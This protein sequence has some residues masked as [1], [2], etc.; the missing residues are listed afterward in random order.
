MDVLRT[1][2]LYLSE[3]EV[4]RAEKKRNKDNQS[5]HTKKK[6]EKESTSLNKQCIHIS[7]INR[8]TQVKRKE[9]KTK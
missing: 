3:E 4:N 8:H 6:K 2:V 5:T 9:K 1:S 7:K